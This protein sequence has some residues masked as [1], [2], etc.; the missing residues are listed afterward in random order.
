[1][2]FYLLR[3]INSVIEQGCKSKEVTPMYDSV[4]YSYY[5]GCNDM[6]VTG[7]TCV[8]KCSLADIIADARSHVYRRISIDF[9]LADDDQGTFTDSFFF[10]H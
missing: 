3:S 2:F 4:Y 10:I 7:D 8:V 1:M 6:V 9:D 5:N